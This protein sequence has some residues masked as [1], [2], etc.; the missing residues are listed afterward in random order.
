M[1]RMQ[2]TKHA[3]AGEATCGRCGGG[4][5]I[6]HGDG[7][8]GGPEEGG[9]GLGKGGWGGGGCKGYAGGVGGGNGQGGGRGG[10][11]GV[12]GR[13]PPGGCRPPP[14][15][16]TRRTSGRSPATAR[17]VDGVGC[18]LLGAAILHA[19]ADTV[20]PVVVVDAGAGEVA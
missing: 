9:C 5:N 1:L 19:D 4:S 16:T 15:C 10:R 3:P 2:S 20:A 7:D 13:S 8:T 17:C 14:Q 11:R 6:G 18:V 12:A